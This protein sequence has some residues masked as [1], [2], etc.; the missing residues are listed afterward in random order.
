MVSHAAARSSSSEMN[1]PQEVLIFRRQVRET[2][3]F[4]PKQRSPFSPR[5]QLT[6]GGGTCGD[7]RPATPSSSVTPASFQPGEAWA[8]GDVEM[9]ISASE[10][11]VGLGEKRWVFESL[12]RDILGKVDTNYKPVKK[13]PELQTGCKRIYTAQ[14]RIE[15]GTGS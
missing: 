3:N 7:V 1:I 9:T 10:F 2:W 13:E 5:R 6:K 8:R 15:F 4:Y 12:L 14:T 11:Q